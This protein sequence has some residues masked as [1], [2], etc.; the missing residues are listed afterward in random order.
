MTWF[1]DYPIECFGDTLGQKAPKRKVNIVSLERDPYVLVD[2]FD[3][4][5]E[6]VSR[7]S[8]KFFYIYMEINEE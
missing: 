6:K 4:D 5:T 1:T 3:L 2:V 7:E 8:I